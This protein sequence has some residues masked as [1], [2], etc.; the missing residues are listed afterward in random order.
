MVAEPEKAIVD[1]LYLRRFE[2]YA[3]EAME[4]REIRREKLVDFAELVGRKSLVKRIEKLL[5]KIEE[6]I[7]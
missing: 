4:S 7:Q 3:E 2:E 6:R 5:E 1:M